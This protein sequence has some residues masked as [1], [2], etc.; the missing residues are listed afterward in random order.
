MKIKRVRIENFCCLHKVDVAFEDITCFIGPTGVGKSTILRALDWFFNGEKSIGLSDTDVHSAAESPRITVEVEFGDLDEYDREVLGSYAPPGAAS[1]IVWRTWEEGEDK[2]SGKALTY[3]P[4]GPVRQQ[5]TAMAMRKE[6]NELRDSDPTLGLPSAGSKPAVLDA[7][8]AWERE[9]RDELTETEVE[10]THFFGFAGQSKLRELIDFVF[11]SA[12]LRAYE[13]AEDHRSSALG[14]ILDHA[15]NRAEANEQLD[16]IE[17]S[18]HQARLGVHSTVYGPVLDG[19]SAAL[20]QEVARFTTGRQVVVSPVVQAPKPA[21]TS[22]QVSIKDG[23]AETSVYRQGH[24]FQRALIIS[25]LKL[26]AERSSPQ[27]GT[28]TLCLAVEEPEL[29]QHPPQARTFA[30]VLRGL[31]ASSSGRTQAMYATHS[32]VFV[33]PRNYHEIR[34]L[35]RDPAEAH[36]VTRVRQ[37]SEA[38][39]CRSLEPRVSEEAIRRQAGIKCAVT[40]AEGFFARAVILVEGDTDAA[41]LLG[42]AERQRISLGAEGVSVISVGSKGNILLCHAILAALDVPTYVVFDGDADMEQRKRESVQHLPEEKRQE[43]EREF[44]NQARGNAEKNADLLGY[45]GAPVRPWPETEAAST[46]AVFRDTL[47]TYLDGDWI[48]WGT[49]RGELISSG[50]GFSRKHAATYREAARTAGTEPPYH[51]LAML[52]SVRTMAGR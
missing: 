41:V 33:D 6:Y 24:G 1:V 10:D 16:V 37:V 17:E 28:R 14:R 21:R 32:P 31:V 7:M 40:L 20:S 46:Y 9:H 50:L 12:D 49:R 45:F 52:E 25:A 43:K 38:E 2:I 51:L 34:R 48:A 23:A 39:L 4:F 11:I 47:E 18:A 5:S 42:C 35:S 44:A 3:P 26:L 22:F 36:P 8:L 13:E 19:L 30:E 27:G 29:F 15:V